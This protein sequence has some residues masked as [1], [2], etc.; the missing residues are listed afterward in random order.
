[1]TAG[2]G[3]AASTK[4]AP[5]GNRTTGDGKTG[6]AIPFAADGRGRLALVSGNAQ[7]EKIITLN[8]SDLESANPYQGDIG[9]GSEMVFAIAS[10]K[11]RAEVQR[12][13][14]LLFRRLQLQDRARLDGIPVFS[15]DSNLQEMT[16]DIKYINLEEDKPGDIGLTF[17]LSQATN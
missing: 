7:L 15:T 2:N 3:G 13:I 17:S 10:V 16:V 14:K 5:A 11:L 12:R 4:G 6:I 9:L 8:L 1:M